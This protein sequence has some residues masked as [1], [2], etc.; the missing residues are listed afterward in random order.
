M[1]IP[2]LP[3]QEPHRASLKQRFALL[4]IQGQVSQMITVGHAIG[5]HAMVG[6]SSIVAEKVIAWLMVSRPILNQTKDDELGVSHSRT[7]EWIKSCSAGD[8]R[9]RR[10][11]PLV[12]SKRAFPSDLSCDNSFR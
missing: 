4:G 1:R 12:T 8:L 5:F 2:V 10:F 6:G 7:G 11:D 9:R 3:T